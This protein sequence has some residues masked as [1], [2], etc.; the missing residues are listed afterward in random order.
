MNLNPFK[1]EEVAFLLAERGFQN[2]QL[3]LIE[4]HK[5]LEVTVSKDGSWH[6]HI[7]NTI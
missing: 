4:I 3:T 7:T 5:H 2:I 1:T 6:K